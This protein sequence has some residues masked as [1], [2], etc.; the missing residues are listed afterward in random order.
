[1]TGAVVS[2]TVTS[3]SCVE[4]LPAASVA[5]QCTVVVPTA[6]TSPEL[7]SHVT[8]SVASTMSVAIGSRYVTVAPLGPVASVSPT[9]GTVI[10]GAVMST[11]VTSNDA[12]DMLG[13]A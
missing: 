11:T 1:M 8:V 3:K 12:V 13:A 9:V 10:D 2:T 5:E 6:N 4:L 7:M